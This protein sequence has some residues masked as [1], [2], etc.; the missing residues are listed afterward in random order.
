M[1]SLAFS[2]G[3]IQLAY[4]TAGTPAPIRVRVHSTWGP[5]PHGPYS[6]V[7]QHPTFLQQ[8]LL[9]PHWVVDAVQQEC[10]TGQPS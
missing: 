10:K 6:E 5:L 4:R 1:H 9:H 3:A 8:I 2:L 7:I